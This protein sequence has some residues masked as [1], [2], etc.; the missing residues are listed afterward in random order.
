MHELKTL[1]QF[2]EA[3]GGGEGYVV[4]TDVTGTAVAH[5]PSCPSVDASNFREKVV[6]NQRRNGRYYWVR[7]ATTAHERFGAHVCSCL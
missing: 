4:I 6:T 2:Y 5:P 1:E 3:V 7:G